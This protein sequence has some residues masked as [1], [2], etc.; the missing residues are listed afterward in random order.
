PRA[1]SHGLVG[2]EK[3]RKAAAIV[4]EIVK[5]E[6]IAGRCR[7]DRRTTKARDSPNL[8]HRMLSL[9]AELT[10]LQDKTA[11]AMGM[12]QSLGPDVPFTMLTSSEIFSIEM[13]V[14]L[15]EYSDLLARLE[16]RPDLKLNLTKADWNTILWRHHACRQQSTIVSHSST[17]QRLPP[18]YGLLRLNSEVNKVELGLKIGDTPLCVSF[19]SDSLE[20]VWADIVRKPKKILVVLGQWHPTATINKSVEGSWTSFVD[21]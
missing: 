14:K 3:A 21:T 7:V 8:L 2:Q 16:E 5:Q 6:K 15:L 1:A 20:G 4:L 12:A 9:G 11:I 10:Y 17:Q 18:S 19:W 13:Q